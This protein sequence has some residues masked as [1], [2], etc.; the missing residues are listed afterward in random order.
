MRQTSDW[1]REAQAAWERPLRV[2]VMRLLGGDG[3][4]ARDVVQDAFVQLCQ[5]DAAAV[6]NVRA[7]LYSVCRNR[8][9]DLARKERRMTALIDAPAEPVAAEPSAMDRMLASEAADAV[10]VQLTRLPKS[11]QEAVR[12]KFQ[13]QLSYKEIAHV[14]N[15]SVSQVGVLLHEAIKTLRTRLA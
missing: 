4:R 6:A 5:Q 11:Q 3:E 9:I 2:Y 14:L 13:E 15:T 8:V 10:V 7:W 1:I 12:L